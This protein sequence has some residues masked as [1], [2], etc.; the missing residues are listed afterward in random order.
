MITQAELNPYQDDT[1]S[2]KK[3]DPNSRIAKIVPSANLNQAPEKK[4]E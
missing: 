2:G 3:P 1:S 4:P